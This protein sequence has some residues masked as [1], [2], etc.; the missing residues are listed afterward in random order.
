[1]QWS[2]LIDLR[3]QRLWLELRGGPSPHTLRRQVCGC[4]CHALS[5]PSMGRESSSKTT[6]SRARRGG[7][8]GW[9]TVGAES[10]SASADRLL[11]TRAVRLCASATLSKGT[12]A[13]PALR[14]VRSR[15]QKRKGPVSA[16]SGARQVAARRSSRQC[17]RARTIDIRCCR[18]VQAPQ[19]AV[20][21]LQRTQSFASK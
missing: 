17:V 1:M 13:D 12:P 20:I 8:P 16:S 6:V 21:C 7:M 4:C 3:R 9:G 19:A 18:R 5:A 2:T 10:G 11:L 15:G 14:D